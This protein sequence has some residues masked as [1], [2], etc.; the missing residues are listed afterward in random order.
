ME[1]TRGVLIRDACIGRYSLPADTPVWIVGARG[2]S[3]EV[4]Y[5][6]AHGVLPTSHVAESPVRRP[7]EAQLRS[8]DPCFGLPED[9]FTKVHVDPENLFAIERCNAH[10]MLFLRDTRGSIGLYERITL[11]KPEESDDWVTIWSRYHQT[12]DDWLNLQGR[13]W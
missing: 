12:S 8:L 3:L 1:P 11:L 9:A 2:E 6:D 5:R 10:G 7:T 4:E 13:T